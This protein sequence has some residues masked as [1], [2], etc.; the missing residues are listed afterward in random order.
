MR[1][2]SLLALIFVGCLTGLE[3]KSDDDDDDDGAGD[4]EL[5]LLQ[6]S[7]SSLREMAGEMFHKIDED[8]DG[9]AS[10]KELAAYL[11]KQMWRA[12]GNLRD[13]KK[14]AN[15]ALAT[16]DHD[17]DG[18]LNEKELVESVRAGLERKAQNQHGGDGDGGDGD[19]EDI[20]N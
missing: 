13:A 20:E 2:V 8:E 17:G 7:E 3:A 12:N 6:E 10:F 5:D 14:D 11:K 9:R 18:Y 16:F 4:E 15:A 19:I 1:K